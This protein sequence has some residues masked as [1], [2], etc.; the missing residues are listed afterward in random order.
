MSISIKTIWCLGLGGVGGFVGG[1]IAES[2]TK[3][4]G[5]Q[6]IYFVA[7]GEH[8]R[9]IQQQGLRLML[10]GNQS[11]VCHP[12][13]ATDDLSQLPPPDLIIVA[14][15]SYDLQAAL[16]PLLPYLQ[17][18]TI[19]LPLLNG[20]DIVER[21]HNVLP[22]T[23][24]LPACIYA[25]VHKEA[26]GVIRQQGRGN[27]LIFGPDPKYLDLNLTSLKTMMTR[28]HLNCEEHYHPWPAIWSKYLFIAPLGM[29]TA[30]YTKTLGE[31][32]EDPSLVH[33]VRLMMEEIRALALARNIALPK[34]IV[35]STLKKLH[36]FPPETKTSFQRDVETQ[37]KANEGELFGPTI[38][39]L[40]KALNRATPMTEKLTALLGLT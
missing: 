31:V 8:L 40:G 7:R 22:E 23:I 30:A 6:H 20:I 27:T 9:A 39:R 29:V 25:G 4:P 3:H 13:L 38:I 12:A 33:Q 19:L 21:C 34:D 14:V 2:L 17:S 28:A 18:T 36:D 26:P 24:I 10:P 37:G 32:A 15:K 11:L 16:K 1:R 5:R 35:E